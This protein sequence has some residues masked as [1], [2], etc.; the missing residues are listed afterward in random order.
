M[1]VAT[2]EIFANKGL[3]MDTHESLL[4]ENSLV[5]L[6]NGDISGYE[7]AG[8]GTF[9]QNVLSNSECL[10]FES[11]Y[12]LIGA[13]PMDRGQYALFFK[14]NGTS[15]VGLF[16][17][18]TCA[19]VPKITNQCLD[20]QEDIRGVHKN[21][22]VYFVEKGN[23]VRFIDMHECLPTKDVSDCGSCEENLQFDC[24][25]FNLSRCVKFP[26]LKITEGQGNLPNGSYQ[27]ALAL[28]DDKQRFT[29]Y[30]VYPQVLRLHT[31][32]QANNR[33]GVEIEF[34]TCPEGFDEYELVLIAH[35]TD[36]ATLAQRVGY[37]GVEQTTNY[38]SE[39]DDPTYAPIDLS[40]L[41][42]TFPHYQSAEH[43]AA[44]D[45]QLLL[46]GVTYRD[47]VN[48]Q[49][50]ARQI[51]SKWVVKQVKAK[52]AH[53][54]MSFMRGE[55]YGMF[56]RGIYCD[57]ERTAWFHL[58]SDSEQ[59]IR[60]RDRRNGTNVW[61]TVTG[62]APMGPDVCISDD[63]CDP[64][65]QAYWELYDSS[66]V[67][68]PGEVEAEFCYT[69]KQGVLGHFPDVC[70]G[71]NPNVAFDRIENFFEIRVLN[72]YCELVPTSQPISIVAEYTLTG[73]DGT[74]VTQQ[75]THTVPIGSSS[76]LHQYNAYTLVDC[77]QGSCLPEFGQF[78]RIISVS[79]HLPECIDGACQERV[80]D[81]DCNETIVARGD[82]GHWQSKLKYP[83]NPCVWG[84]R[85]DPEKPFYDPYGLSCQY[86]RYHRFPD[87]CTTHIH[88]S[89]ECDGEELVNILGIEFYNIRPF[90]DKAGVPIKD[91]VG[92]EIGVADRSNQKSILHKGLIYNMW[93]EDLADC[94][95]S[96]YANYPFNDLNPDVFL[97]RT[98]A[99]Y[100]G[101]SAQYGEVFYNPVTKY[102]KDRFQ[103]IS[104]EVS[105]ERNDS[106]THLQ[107]FAEENGFV[108]GQYTQTEEM[109]WVTIIS[110]LALGLVAGFSIALAITL[111]QSVYSVV[112]GVTTLMNSLRNGLPPVNYAINYFAK[113]VYKGHNCQN[114]VPGNMIRRI[115][116][117]QY[118]LPTKMLV[119]VDKVNNTQRE[120]G[121][122]LRLC[123]E[124]DNPFVQ[125]YSR[126][127]LSDNDCRSSFDFCGSV[128]G[129]NPRT[130]SYYAGVRVPRPVQYNMP[131][132]N[133]VRTITEV[134][135]WNNSVTV[136]SPPIFGG[137]VHITKHKYV[138]KFPFFRALPLGLPNNTQYTTSTYFNVW[139]TRYWLDV[140]EQTSLLGIFN[141]G[142]NDSR[143]L[144]RA[145]GPN[146]AFCGS[147]GADCDEN[148][149]LRIDG[150]FYTHVVGEA[151]YW[152][153][154]EYIGDFRELNEI[155]ESDVER[156][157]D[158]K[159]E[160][161]TVQYPE[162]FLYNQQYKWNGY[163]PF[164]PTFDSKFDCCKPFKVDSRNT[165]AY[166]IK[167]DPLSR[168]DAWRKFLPNS[169][170][171]FSNRDG[172]LIGIRE[173]D[174]YNLLVA[175]EDA[176]YIT[177]QDETLT[178]NNGTSL[179][180]GNPDAFSRRMRKI[181]DDATGFGGCID[182]DSVVNTRYGTFWIDRKRKKL[183]LFN[184]Q[185]SD[186]TGN[187]QSW[188][189][190]N[191]NG[192]VIGV[193]DNYSDNLYFTGQDCKWTLSYKPRL[194]DWVS[195]HSFTPE[196]YLSMPN[197]FLSSNGGGIW[198]HN[199]N[200]EYQRYYGVPYAFDVGFIMKSKMK[201]L[202]L[203][204]IEVY[205]E[206][207]K[208]LNYGEKVYDQKSFFDKILVFN[209]LRSTG[210]RDIVVKDPN[211]AQHTLT[212][213]RSDLTECSVIEDFTYR[214]NKFPASQIVGP[215]SKMQCM[216]YSVPE[217]K[218]ADTSGS[219]LV[220]P[221][222][223]GWFR[224]HL[225]NSSRT[226]HKIL[227]KLNV[228]NNEEVV[229]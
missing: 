199:K 3:N 128:N 88:N 89:A 220:A 152:C 19:Y 45:E 163:T 217:Y 224:T 174:D 137:D 83:D 209:Q 100:V 189:N 25:G 194:R 97:S 182:L 115:E 121:L 17:S 127:R 183:I 75:I 171:Q 4:P 110:D 92:Y 206:W 62:A 43:I 63:P 74:I 49:P 86:V 207:V 166:S 116:A 12:S 139:N 130:S 10:T 136:A 218:M 156:P 40:V 122:Y 108:E 172:A 26:K 222:R 47:P 213:N 124:I 24:E 60:E 175:F 134:Q 41:G 159:K 157:Y 200:Y 184:G 8:N 186:V 228:G 123:G 225:I 118:T 38:I 42:E 158:Q 71:E 93:E 112:E 44:N 79:T 70:Q 82:F 53:K 15:E 54:H 211:N 131:E 150:K 113:T 160:Y 33:F 52:D 114:V 101:G 67:D 143:N 2:Q 111:Q 149:F 145:G 104:P 32:N 177:Q 56:I 68:S 164:G 205:A 133:L 169:I 102:A 180:I 153:E 216:D 106:G 35:R 9:V 141:L 142:A 103:Y 168:G 87:N 1:N 21:G 29:E 155:P 27:V 7:N 208:F 30:Y 37:F 221:M 120:S 185:V 90:V 126:I 187:M 81:E 72:R 162:M 146:K 191:L 14:G 132:S 204:S 77:G 64:D 179:F 219:G 80:P 226:G 196:R 197:N 98:P 178:T 192:P 39:L 6:L 59:T 144:E 167:H 181:S 22:R 195:F 34:E 55:R 201:D 48:Y 161:R 91:I 23:P 119:D 227:L 170:Q 13:V 85:T 193:Y 190:E 151:H 69:A 28:T 58:P 51:R 84:Q 215:F 99:I 223:G 203:Q 73:C 96:Y 31:N 188:L 50:R 138:R 61:G 66:T 65:P 129:R 154:S 147:T 57:N 210:V 36:R 176:T 117:S 135:D 229:Q 198:K 148:L 95:K 5:Y 202:Q 140:N 16:D 94:T 212:Q 105:F 107:L 78:D 109:P 125:E 76:M 165:L 18:E 46:G 11:G 214:I 20:F 173:I